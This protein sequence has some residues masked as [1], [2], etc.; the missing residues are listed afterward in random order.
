MTR[1]LVAGTDPGAGATTVAVGLAHRLAYAGHE[2]RLERLGGDSR[3]EHDAQVFGLLELA[4][5]SGVPVEADE[6]PD[7]EVATVVEA[8]AGGDPVALAEQLQAR[9]VLVG[10]DVHDAPPGATTIT[11][12]VPVDP[13]RGANGAGRLPEDRLLAAPTAGRL[14]E[15]SNARVLIRSLEGENAICEHIV[16]G[17]I[18]HDPADDYMRR[19]PRKAVVT[20][21]EKVDLALGAMITGAELLLLTGGFDPSPYVLDRAAST[22]DTTLAVTRGGTVETLRDI[23]GHFGTVPFSHE[24]KVERIGELMRTAIDDEMLSALIAR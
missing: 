20:R 4:E 3:A 16:I 22:R 1:I 17:A 6:L 8:P 2:V 24:S 11:N 19:F 7:G 12:Q 18:S 9:L 23:E 13:R 21:S 5:A 15:A 10:R 14:L